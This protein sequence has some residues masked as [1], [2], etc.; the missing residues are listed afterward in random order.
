[1]NTAAATYNTA[2]RHDRNVS[3]TKMSQQKNDQNV[4]A[5]KKTGSRR[6]HSWSKIWLISMNGLHF[7]KVAT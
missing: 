3:L 4:S 2:V 6:C 5:N 1:M 7:S